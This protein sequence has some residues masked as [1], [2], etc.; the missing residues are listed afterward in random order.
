MQPALVR[1][2]GREAAADLKGLRVVGLRERDETGLTARHVANGEA[3]RRR[4]RI[5]LVDERAAVERDRH[6][7]GA[8]EAA[9]E[10]LLERLTGAARAQ[11]DPRVVDRASPA[12]QDR[13]GVLGQPGGYDA[14]AG[15][16]R[17]ALLR[18]RLLN[19]VRTRPAGPEDLTR[20]SSS[21]S[22]TSGCA[23]SATHRV[24][25]Q[26]TPARVRKGP[27]VSSGPG[28]GRS[29]T[30]GAAAADDGSASTTRARASAVRMPLQHAGEAEDA[31]AAAGRRTACPGGA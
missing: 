3:D 25:V 27:S 1:Q 21:L 30:T 16:G 5:G 12:A 2:P 22:P 14:S 15:F 17:E 29:V 19:R 23:Q 13:E 8:V 4:A 26:P 7:V 6:V 9:V 18:I 10:E 31:L 24:C 11:D 28:K 20:Y